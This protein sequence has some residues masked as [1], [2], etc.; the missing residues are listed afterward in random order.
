M[1]ARSPP[2]VCG[3][4]AKGLVPQRLGER[5]APVVGVIRP[6]VG[7]RLRGA[8]DAEVGPGDGGSPRRR[9][10]LAMSLA[11]GPEREPP[12]TVANT[13]TRRPR[14]A[15]SAASQLATPA[16]AGHRPCAWDR[17][18]VR[19]LGDPACASGRRPR[20]GRR[21][22][23]MGGLAR[24]W[25][26]RLRS[27]SGSRP[28]HQARLRDDQRSH[29]DSWTLSWVVEPRAIP[30]LRRRDGGSDAR[31]WRRGR[32]A[33]GLPVEPRAPS[34]EELIHTAGVSRASAHRHWPT[35]GHFT[36]DLLLR[37][38]GA[39][40]LSGEI[41]GLDEAFALLPH[42][43]CADVGIASGRGTALV[44]TSRVRAHTDFVAML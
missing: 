22:R 20:A 42:S 41:P 11:A 12:A 16:V 30:S 31:R 36:A 17:R 9:S 40:D 8:L 23:V 32:A 43:V 38:A 18:R 13:T 14:F 26:A 1:A 24:G 29:A 7:H 39:A 19:C 4:A 44:E 33:R 37:L 27:H 21:R 34:V 6:L 15:S 28:C 3:E 5:S 10:R 35:K 25:R 2:R